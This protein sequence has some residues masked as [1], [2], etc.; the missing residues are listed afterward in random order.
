[1]HLVLTHYGIT[2]LFLKAVIT[3]KLL[4]RLLNERSENYDK[5]NEKY[6]IE[7]SVNINILKSEMFLKDNYEGDMRK[8]IPLVVS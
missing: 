3:L 4:M 5:A 2:F 7:I 6:D 1:M 8:I